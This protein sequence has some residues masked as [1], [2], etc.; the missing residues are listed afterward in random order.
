MALGSLVTAYFSGF[1]LEQVSVRTVFG[2]VAA[3]PLLIAIAAI[4]IDESPTATTMN[5]QGVWGQVKQLKQAVTQKS[6][7]L[8]TGF[9]F[10]W[11]ATPS[12][13][14]AMF[15]FTTNELGFQPEFL[16]R[17]RLVASI[18]AILGIW[19][20]QR[21]LKAVPFRVIF[22]WGTVLSTGLGLTT[23]L[24]VTHAN[25]AI[26]IDDYWFSLGDTLVLTVVGEI[27]F[28]PVLVLAARICPPGVE[29]TLFA[30]LMSV[31][32]LGGVLSAETGALIMQGLGITEN[33]FEH[34]WI[35][36]LITNLSTLLPL[37]LLFWL[38]DTTAS[39]AAPI[40]AASPTPA[41]AAP[42]DQPTASAQPDVADVSTPI[43]SPSPD[44]VEMR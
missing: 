19:I 26:G 40:A 31:L 8:P 32:N 16:G 39:D 6:V 27:A 33:Q 35:L 44:P 41:P 25:R 13:E 37:P 24:L 30:L 2:L 14:S 18:A 42:S 7:W 43:V 22:A 23:L 36:V 10:L 29:A 38:P 3:L 11:M 1:L 9:I 34:L 15:F 4:L 17:V 21:F 5:W 20:F 28:M 12:A